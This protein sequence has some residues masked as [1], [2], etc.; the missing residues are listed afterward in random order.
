MRAHTVA[1]REKD[2]M[3]G[4]SYQFVARLAQTA[5]LGGLVSSLVPSATY[6]TMVD[7]VFC[8]Q[9]VTPIGTDGLTPPS[10]LCSDLLGLPHAR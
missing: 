1:G 3:R 8:K 4:C 2:G 10:R 9:S 6:D 7:R 5:K